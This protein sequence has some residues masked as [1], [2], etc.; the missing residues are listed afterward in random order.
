VIARDERTEIER[1]NVIYAARQNVRQVLRRQSWETGG[2]VADPFPDLDA[3]RPA[4][5][6]FMSTG[7][8]VWIGVGVALGTA[9]V[10]LWVLA[11]LFS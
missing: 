7:V 11:P 10:L 4:T 1:E 9:L 6:T 5:R 8:K 2:D 3:P